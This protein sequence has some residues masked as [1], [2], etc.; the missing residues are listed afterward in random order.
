MTDERLFFFIFMLLFLSS[1]ALPAGDTPP[2]TSRHIP[3]VPAYPP[4][5]PPASADARPPWTHSPPSSESQTAPRPHIPDT[6]PPDTILS[7]PAD[8]TETSAFPLT[9]Q[10]IP[11][12]APRI[13][14]TADC[15]QMSALLP[16]SPLVS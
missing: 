3:T 9:T 8:G 1:T 12:S 15:P 6:V 7:C 13:S 16:P 10:N 11:S 2:Q 14:G 4:Q 5:A